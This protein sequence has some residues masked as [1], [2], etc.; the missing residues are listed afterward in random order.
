MTDLLLTY[1]K[2]TMEYK[3][4]IFERVPAILR[5]DDV[6]E[7]RAHAIHIPLAPG[8]TV[9]VSIE[10]DEITGIV[11]LV[12]LWTVDLDFKLPSN[13][14]TG[15]ALPDDDPANVTIREVT[16]GWQREAWVTKHTTFS[17]Y[18]SAQD[19]EWLEDRVVRCKYVD[20]VQMVRHPGMPIDFEVARENADF[21][22]L[23]GPWV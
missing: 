15:K 13:I 2:L 17:F 1:P 6:Y 23:R 22:E 20:D 4:P 21:G 12:P 7:L 16:E 11:E 9:T 19:R 18:V 8:D 3:A 10:N 5:A 14:V